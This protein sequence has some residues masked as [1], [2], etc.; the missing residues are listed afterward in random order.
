MPDFTVT[1]TASDGNA[2]FEGMTDVDFLEAMLESAREAISRYWSTDALGMRL[3]LREVN[4]NTFGHIH[5]KK[6]NL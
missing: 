1:I 5:V 3:P 6:E 4:G 2:A